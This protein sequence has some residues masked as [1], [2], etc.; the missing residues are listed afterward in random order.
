MALKTQNRSSREGV[1]GMA[2]ESCASIDVRIWHREGRLHPGQCFPYSWTYGGQPLASITVWTE[3]H[4]IVLMF[5]ARWS[6]DGEWKSVEQRV[7][8]TWTPCH[9]GG[10][11]AWFRCN[12]CSNGHFCG[13]RVAL[14]YAAGELFACRHCYGL[15][16]AS[17]RECLRLR[18][19]GRAQKIRMQ[20]GGSGNMFDDFPQKPKGMHWRT[21]LRL[22]HSHDIAALRCGC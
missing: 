15:A 16:Y 18:G 10:S 11:R 22:R 2:C 21:Y 13:R 8:I 9:L 1:G 5:R 20:L 3:A 4:A 19:L 14:L 17:Q 7:P 12:V 6:E